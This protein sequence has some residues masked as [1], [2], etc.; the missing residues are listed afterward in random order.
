LSSE[1]ADAKNAE[2]EDRILRRALKVTRT[3][4][5]VDNQVVYF[6]ILFFDA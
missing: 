5:T 3:G 4:C 2:R 6:F 1:A